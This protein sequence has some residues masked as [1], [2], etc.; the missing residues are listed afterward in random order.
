[1]VS[2]MPGFNKT[3]GRHTVQRN[4]YKAGT[5]REDTELLEQISEV[6]FIDQ[7]V[8]IPEVATDICQEI[9]SLVLR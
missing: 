1:M 5:A 8:T 9:L 6:A 2:R 7:I 4:T 3:C